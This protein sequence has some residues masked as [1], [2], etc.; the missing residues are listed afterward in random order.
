MTTSPDVPLP[1]LFPFR[2]ALT[3]CPPPF[4]TCSTALRLRLSHPPLTEQSAGDVDDEHEHDQ[5]ERGLPCQLD[6]V[7]ER[8]AR[9]VLDEHGQRRG[10]LAEL[11][12]RLLEE[13]EAAEERREDQGRRLA[14]CPRHRQHHAG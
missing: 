3:S 8:H 10:R 6:L 5:R 14:R 4:T 1:W 2:V 9:E 11:Q 7:L 12:A 13:P